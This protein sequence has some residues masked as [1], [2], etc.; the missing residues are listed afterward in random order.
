MTDFAFGALTA[1][2]A[3]GV[4]FL[5]TCAFGWVKIT[6][7]V[8]NAGIII[9]SLILMAAIAVFEEVVS[10]GYIL[11][12]LRSGYGTAAAV[13]I[14]SAIFASLH[15]SNAGG[16][17]L[18]ALSGIFAA[19]IVLSYAYITTKRLWLPIGIHF[20]WNL[21]LGP[22]FGFRVSGNDLPSLIQLHSNGPTWWL[23]GKF[24]PESGLWAIAALILIAIAL[25]RYN[26]SSAAQDSSS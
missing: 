9:E 15:F 16:R 8:L 6:G 5:I 25:H 2:S 20:G 10:R 11:Q 18:A 26:A 19:G 21:A 14:N 12:T 24:G 22:I 7:F 4:L 13:I 23:G 1:I 3:M 17:S